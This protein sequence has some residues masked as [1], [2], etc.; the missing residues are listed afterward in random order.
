MITLLRNI[1][2]NNIEVKKQLALIKEQNIDVTN[3]ENELEEFKTGF[4]RNYDLA[5]ESLTPL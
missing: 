3:F 4:S 5:K 1:A 2:M